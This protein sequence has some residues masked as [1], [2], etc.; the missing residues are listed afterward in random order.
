MKTI[1]VKSA[2]ASYEEQLTPS[3]AETEKECELFIQSMDE[4]KKVFKPAIVDQSLRNKY[5]NL[6]DEAIDNELKQAENE[7]TG[8]KP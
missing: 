2:N 8:F 4:F 7:K 1:T 6:V 3:L 5:K